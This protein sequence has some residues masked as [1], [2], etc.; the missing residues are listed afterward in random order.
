KDTLAEEMEKASDRL[1][2][3]RAAALRDR[4]EALSTI[5]SHQGVHPRSVENADIFACHQQ[6]GVTCIEVFFIRNFQNWG[7]RAYYPR[8]D[9]SLVCG[10]ILERFL[11]Q[12]YESRAA[13]SM[14]L[15][16]HD[17]EERALL[18]E[19]LSTKSDHRV[20]V[21]LPQRGE[22]RELVEHA[23]MNARAA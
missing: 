10:E 6:G 1:D 7:D 13:P 18:A 21:A 15:L 8:A 3:E 23:L 14:V 16:S 2:F 4:L 9:R 20:E 19:A 17:I 5:Q 22:K 11:P 12:F